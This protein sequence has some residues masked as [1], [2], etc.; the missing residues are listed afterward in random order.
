VKVAISNSGGKDTYLA[1][2]KA[3]DEGYEP[4]VSLTMLHESLDISRSHA[5]PIPLLHLQASQYGLPLLHFRASWAQYESAF[6]AMLE[7]AKKDFAIEG[8][9]FGD[10]C[11]DANKL[12]GEKICNLARLEAIHPIWQQDPEILWQETQALGVQAFICS[13]LP[14]HKRILGSYLSQPIIDYLSNSNADIF[15]EKGEYHTFVTNGINVEQY[16]HQKVEIN[17]YCFITYKLS[18]LQDGTIDKF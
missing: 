15:G 12:W 6:L 7:Q 14:E 10:R 16:I 1:M 4:V 5:I 18:S 11:F 17:N 9:V 3:K 13:C 8:V 2:Q